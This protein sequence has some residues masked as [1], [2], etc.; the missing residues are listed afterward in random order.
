[1]SSKIPLH[2]ILVRSGAALAGIAAAVVIAACGTTTALP[3]TTTTTTT[4]TLPVPVEVLATQPIGSAAFEGP[5][6]RIAVPL[7][8]KGSSTLP[9]RPVTQRTNAGMVRIAYRQFGSGPNLVLAMGE[10]GSMTWWDPTF[11]DTLSQSYRVT[12]F[13][14][15]AVGFSAS[16]SRSPSV[17][18]YGDLMAGMIASLGLDN[19]T[20]LGWGMG[21]EAALSLVERH[22]KIA[23]ALVLVDSTAGG[24]ASVRPT[25]AYSSVI[26]A[27]DSTM[28]ELSRVMY[29]PTPAGDAARRAWLSNILNL[30]PD[31]VLFATVAA[32]AAAQ[33]A[34]FQDDR[35]ARLLS[36]ITVPVWIFQGAQDVIIPKQNAELLAMGIPGATITI[37][38]DAGYAGLFQD[39]VTFLKDL[40][41]FTLRVSKVTTTTAGH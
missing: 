19:V 38:P 32:Q 8:A 26:G 22:P 28:V 10:H 41:A 15:P 29:P 13:D 11:L 34:Y 16:L 23:V 27:S 3:T 2:R 21:G 24:P 39:S 5:V 17:E 1:M 37:A 31:D 18:T 20:I 30:A 7:L 33:N 9:P 12:I 40:S 25:A 35:V 14:A 6:Y 36:S 4:T